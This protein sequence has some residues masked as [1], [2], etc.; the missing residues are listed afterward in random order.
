MNTLSI[1]FTQN[2]KSLS[3]LSGLKIFDDLISQFQL[4]SFFAPFLPRKVRNS[5]F[6]CWDKFYTL[7]LGFIAGADCLDDFDWLSHD[8]LFQKLTSAPS[9]ITLGRFLR[10]FSLRQIEQLQ[11][12]LPDLALSF[13]VKRESNLKKII[14]T[15]DSSD[16]Q[17]YGVK[18]EGVEF[19]YKKFPCLNSQNI[20]D[21]K[22][23]CYG[24]KLR[25]G[26]TY[27]SIDASEMIY[28]TLKKIP[29]EIQT[30]LR[31]DSA[32][33]SMEIYN[34]CLNQKCHFAIALKENVWSS[35]LKKYARHIK[36]Q[37]TSLRFFD[38]D[39]CQ[40]GTCLY[41]LTGLAM[42]KKFLRVVFIRTHKLNPTK[43]DKHTHHYYAIVTDLTES[44]MSNEQIIKFY[45][46]RAQ[47]ENNI[48][49]IKNGMDFH[50][51]PCMSLK[52]NNV[53]GIIGVIAYN[54]MRYASFALVPERGCFVKTT[55]KKLVT[56]A[57]EIIS[58]ARSIEIRI[59]SYVFKEVERIR[60]M[61][62]FV[63]KVV[64]DRL[65]SPRDTKT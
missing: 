5:G 2:A 10:K 41:P 48:K 27:S 51:F 18:S 32:Y 44:E 25:K 13:R 26:S 31:A 63:S 56:I 61:M 36:W 23:Y 11:F 57:G 64:T 1:N 58:H 38:S 9:S 54:L 21:D 20:F 15:I 50:H 35:I 62:Q 8:P 46:K 37:G 6:R 55:R 60:G 19:G 47:I 16:H 42:D 30:F 7:L 4:K 34:T 33:S 22:G 45:R 52:A 29:S 65:G 59:I 14:F 24:F 3:S 39:K 53:W 49:D 40:L 12:L 43:D 17:Q 28:Q